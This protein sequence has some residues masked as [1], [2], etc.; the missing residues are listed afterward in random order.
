[1]GPVTVSDGGADQKV[2]TADN[3]P[4]ATQGVFIP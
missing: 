3:F 4:F 2:S 1:M